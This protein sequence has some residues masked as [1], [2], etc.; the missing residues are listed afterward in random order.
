MIFFD[1]LRALAGLSGELAVRYLELVDGVIFHEPKDGIRQIL[2]F[3]LQI[4]QSLGAQ[5][6][7]VMQ[8]DERPHG[9][10]ECNLGEMGGHAFPGILVSLSVMSGSKL[11]EKILSDH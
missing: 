9:V 6:D 7:L 10:L 8:F 3:L 2:L 1:T 5:G 4:S 11:A